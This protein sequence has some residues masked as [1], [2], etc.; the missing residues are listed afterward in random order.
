MLTYYLKFPSQA[1]A[2]SVLGL[3]EENPILPG[4]SIDEVGLLWDIPPEYNEDGEIIT[5]GIHKEGWHINVLAR[6]LEDVESILT[7]PDVDVLT[8]TTPARRFAGTRADGTWPNPP[9][10]QKL[11]SV[12]RGSAV[13]GYALTHAAQEL[14]L[15]LNAI[16]AEPNDGEIED[17]G[18]NALYLCHRLSVQGSPFSATQIEFINAA[19]RDAF[20]PIALSADGSSAVILENSWTVEGLAD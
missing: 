13:F 20:Y 17:L 11:K 8:P 4:I 2:V 9:C 16:I 7:H 1:V 5:P 15:F 3:D 18:W 12:F 14:S 6:N 10:H 19:F